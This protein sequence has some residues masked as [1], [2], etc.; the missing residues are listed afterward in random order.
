MTRRESLLADGLLL[1]VTVIWGTSFALTKQVLVQVPNYTYT[2]IRYG[3]AFVALA[4]LAGPNL[5][6][7]GSKGWRDAALLG[8]L[9]LLGFMFQTAGLRLTSSTHSAFITAL[10]VPLV[11]FA[12]IS[13]TG[14]RPPLAAWIGCMMA[15]AGCA[16]LTLQPGFSLLPGDLI[17][18]GCAFVWAFLIVLIGELLPRYHALAMTAAM[19]AVCVVGAGIM[20]LALRESLP[21]AATLPWRQILWLGLALGGFSMWAQNA[22]QQHTPAYH[23]AIIF[24]LE[25]DRKSVV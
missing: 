15:F 12:C 13:I 3:L 4:L 6:R 23:A 21:P 11:P 8:G 10:S 16:V 5:W 17:S 1:L 25:P 19:A 18:L 7:L 22:A 24:S 20:A 9:L 2:A 14:K